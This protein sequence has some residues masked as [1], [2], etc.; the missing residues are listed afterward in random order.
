MDENDLK[1][2]HGDYK[3]NVRS[4]A[5]V[6][7]NDHVLLHKLVSDDFW[8]LPGGRVKFFE[9]S[10][11]TISRELKEELDWDSEVVRH[12]WYV[13]SFFKLY[14]NQYHELANYFLTRL[15]DVDAIDFDK[16][17]YEIGRE[18]EMIFK[19]FK[20]S[21]ITYLNL[22]PAFLK[23]RLMHLPVNVEYIKI[24]NLD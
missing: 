22:K 8:A 11:S 6:I 12:L 15:V 5:V 9:F 24:N 3:L 2:D 23:D 14:D 4:V 18:N 1:F 19:W 20:L 21:N 13:E 16:E 7:E 10:E 17:F